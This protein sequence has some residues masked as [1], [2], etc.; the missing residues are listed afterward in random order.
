MIEAW[1]NSFADLYADATGGKNSEVLKSGIVDRYKFDEDITPA[2]VREIT[3]QYYE[4]V[5]KS[6]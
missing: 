6:N 1:A 5:N 4:E 3:K 2:K